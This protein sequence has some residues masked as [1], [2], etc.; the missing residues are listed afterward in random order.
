MGCT[1][2]VSV[3]LKGL[4]GVDSVSVSMKDVKVMLKPGNKVTIEQI[5]K[6]IQHCGFG[7]GDSEVNVAGILSVVGD[8][9]L[10]NVPG[11]NVKFALSDHTDA[12]GT[13]AKLLQVGTAHVVSVRGTVAQPADRDSTAVIPILQVRGFETG[14]EI[15]RS[16]GS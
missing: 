13:V 16:Q 10:L 14:G 7:A 8:T 12:E 3:V 6:S 9:V 15:T 2:A 4:D 1:N 5:R 11:P